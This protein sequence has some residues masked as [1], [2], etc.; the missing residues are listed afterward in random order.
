MGPVASSL[1]PILLEGSCGM[2]DTALGPP[3][4]AR[5]TLADFW[6]ISR[7]VAGADC[8]L[9]RRLIG[10]GVSNGSVEIDR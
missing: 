7:I 3:G 2:A 1:I 6:R 8:V 4:W 9:I 5:Y 10:F